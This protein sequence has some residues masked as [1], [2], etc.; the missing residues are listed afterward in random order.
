MMKPLVICCSYGGNIR[1]VAEIKPV[2]PYTRGYDDV[3]DRGL[4]EGSG[5]FA[6]GLCKPAL[7]VLG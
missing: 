6:A 7:A 5:H 4:G 3:A 2:K 1:R